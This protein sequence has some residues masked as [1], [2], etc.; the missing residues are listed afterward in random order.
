[1]KEQQLKML[2]TLVDFLGKT[3]GPDYEVSLYNLNDINHSLVAIANSHISGKEPGAP[4]PTIL[5]HDLADAAVLARGYRLNYSGTSV[6]NKTLRTSSIYFKD[7]ENHCFA[8]LSIAF[9]D[10]RYQD[11]SDR[12]L[13]LCHPDF[14]V[15]TNFLYNSDEADAEPE[16]QPA[17]AAESQPNPQPALYTLPQNMD[18]IIDYYLTKNNL[19]A[20]RLTAEGKF[21]LIKYLESKGIFQMRGAVKEVSQ[22]LSCSV[23]SIYRHL[24]KIRENE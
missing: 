4:L 21:E 8:V 6:G 1:M 5:L 14:F 3:L 15:N 24:S 18:Q 12:V 20:D 16:I 10:S 2:S 23:A 22:R 19:Q 11:M 13:K 7:S 17:P 9:D